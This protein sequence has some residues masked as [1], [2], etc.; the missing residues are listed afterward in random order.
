MSGVFIAFLFI[1]QLVSF[2]LI[3]I[4]YTRLTKQK[5]IE[6][7]HQVLL[8]EMDDAVS[9]YLLEIKDENNRLLEELSRRSVSF[10]GIEVQQGQHKDEVEFSP[11]ST[12]SKLAV[13]KLYKQTTQT[14]EQE[15]F[16]IP[17]TLK[18][19]GSLSKTIS[20]KEQVEGLLNSGE[21][22]EQIAKQLGKGKTEIELILKFGNE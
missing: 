21:S 18:E 7:K 12:V 14:K 10:D 22:I 8:R 1:L 17:V 13:A 3:A 15:Y 2:F 19:Q 16:S 4:L 9:A 11:R 20:L 5:D 6:D